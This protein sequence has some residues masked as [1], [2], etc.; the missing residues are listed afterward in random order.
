MFHGLSH[1]VWLDDG[2]IEFDDALDSSCNGV[3]ASGKGNANELIAIDPVEVHAWNQRHV[4]VFEYSRRVVDRI[5]I[6]FQ[7]LL[8]GLSV[9]IEGA[10]SGCGIAPAQSLCIIQHQLASACEFCDLGIGGLVGFLAE[11]FDGCM[12]PCRRWTQ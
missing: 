4:R 9:V 3:I 2:L 12:L 7:D 10:V 5:A 6:A 1:S 8:G 11:S